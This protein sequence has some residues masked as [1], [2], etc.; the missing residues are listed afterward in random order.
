MATLAGAIWALTRWYEKRRARRKL[1]RLQR[2]KHEKE[3]LIR[4]IREEAMKAEKT[5]LAQDIVKMTEKSKN[6]RVSIRT[7]KGTV[8][9]DTA[10]IAYFK[11]DGNYTQMVTFTGHDTIQT[12][13]GALTKMLDP[14]I[15]VRADRSTLVNIHN[16]ERLDARKRLCTFRSADGVEI[17]TSLLAPAF[18]R[19]EQVL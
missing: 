8:I 2:E 5:E 11:A 4:A 17:E 6:T 9:L 16:I 3:Q 13:I 1:A 7:V 18:K 12:G 14:K 15:F 19:L 10:D